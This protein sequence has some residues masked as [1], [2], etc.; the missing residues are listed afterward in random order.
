VDDP[1]PRNPIAARLDPETSRE[2][3]LAITK[4]GERDRQAKLVLDAVR[5]RPGSTSAELAA[6]PGETLDR[7]AF[8]RRLPE[9][10]ELGLIRQEAPRRCQVTGR[11]SVTWRE[12][13]GGLVQ[14]RL[15]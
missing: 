4:S 6:M 13:Q 10:K 8:A 9:L 1:R 15:F 3:A 12:V 11:S 14:E 2:A 7:F 5:R